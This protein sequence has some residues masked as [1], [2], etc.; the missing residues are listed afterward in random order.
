[1]DRPGGARPKALVSQRPDGQLSTAP[2]AP[3]DVPLLV[4][5][6][7]RGDPPDSGAI[8]HAYAEMARAAGIDVPPTWVLGGFFAVRRF[9]RAPR[10][11]V[12]TLAGLLHAD[13]R[14][15]SLDYEDGLKATR[16]LTRDQRAVMSCSGGWRS[17][18][19]RATGT[20]TAGTSHSRWTMGD[21]G[22]RRPRT[23]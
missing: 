17:T 23:T 15:P 4:K 3:D 8:E 5:F 14:I 20:T 13:H 2:A 16:W 22:P 12:H 21:D 9:D 18:S 6:R 19:S 7:G 1:M 10:R 11:H